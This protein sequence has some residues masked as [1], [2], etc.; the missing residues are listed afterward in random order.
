VSLDAVWGGR[1]DELRD[2]VLE[3]ATP[4]EKFRVVERCL[5]A[6]AVRPLTRHPALAYALHELESVPQ[7]RPISELTDHVG[8]SARRFIQIFPEQVGLPPKL[9]CRVQRFREVLQR[10]E[11]EGPVEWADVALACG[12]YDQAHFIHE[13]RSFSG[14][15]PSAYLRARGSH[16][17]HLPLP[18]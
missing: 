4:A 12:Y 16:R 1:A 3:A 6:W 2:R 9:F 15:N 7:P 13:F 10:V 14:L 11:G 8:L 17:G 5:Y 18:D